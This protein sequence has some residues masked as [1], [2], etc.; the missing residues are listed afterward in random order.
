VGWLTR[1]RDFVREVWSELKKTT[2]PTQREVYSTT[3]VVI[4]TVLICAVYL[5]VVDKIL[6]AG[7]TRIFRLFG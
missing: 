5:F 1:F 3:L 4:V 2:W 6:E 7:M